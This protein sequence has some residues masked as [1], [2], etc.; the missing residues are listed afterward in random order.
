ML[1]DKEDLYM[2]VSNYLGQLLKKK[3]INLVTEIP[4]ILDHFS[5]GYIN[6]NPS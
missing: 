3:S 2:N 6:I 4:A 5:R 1:N